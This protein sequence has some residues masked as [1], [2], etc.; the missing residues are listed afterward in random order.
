MRDTMHLATFLRIK[1]SKNNF[2]Q[3]NCV[4]YFWGLLGLV[5]NHVN[6]WIWL[7]RFVFVNLMRGSLI[8]LY[9]ESCRFQHP[10]FLY[11]QLHFLWKLC[12]STAE[13]WFLHD[14]KFFLTSLNT[15]KPTYYFR[16]ISLTLTSST[17]LWTSSFD[18]LNFGLN[19]K[20]LFANLNSLLLLHIMTK[21]VR[22]VF[23]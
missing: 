9:L 22:F 13:I 14:R 16:S 4:S 5:R 20:S 10:N 3:K 1:L 21:Y 6:Q 8:P 11:L 12:Y 15:P 23:W 17:S 18:Q 2:G 19:W 7:A